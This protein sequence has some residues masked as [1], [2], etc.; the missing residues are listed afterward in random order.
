MALDVFDPAFIRCPFAAY[1]RARETGA[2]VYV[3]E[4]KGFWLV[5]DHAQVR[6]VVGDVETFSSRSGPLAAT[7][8][9]PAARQRMAAI[10][11]PEGVRGRVATLLTLDPPE[12]TRNRRLISR[13]FTP[14]SVRRYEELTRQICRELIAPWRDG[15]EIDFVAEFAVPLPIRII[16]AAL[17]V[18]DDR[19]G[20]F[21]RWSDAAVSG[22]GADLD[23]DDVVA[24]HEALLELG[25]FTQA[26]IERKR[27]A[28][29]AED[30]MSRLVHA[31]LDASDRE[32]LGDEAPSQL[33]D[34]EIHSIIRQ[35]L[36]AGN[37]TT[38]NLLAQS[39]VLL[40]DL[41]DWW[42]RMAAE[43]E[44]IT[45]V[46]EEALRYTSPS[47]ANQRACTRDV[48]LHGAKMAEGDIVLV[49]YLA[50]DHD[51]RVFPDPEV[52]DP[53]RPNLAQH[54]AFGRG[55]HFCPGAALAR[56]EARIAFEELTTAI[57]SY[58][59]PDR[60]TLEWNSSFQLRAMLRLPLR[61]RRQE[62]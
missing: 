1:H 35:L 38:T 60:A 32:E 42:R 37:E 5:T 47:A 41:P 39:I 43:P 10:T 28:G 6:E 13:A 3:S 55:V 57:E 21:K 2:S 30:V 33:T 56:M 19:V 40:H 46:V 25:D 29:P 52:F 14:A 53:D 36:V 7:T 44:V 23:D 26:Q 48:D 4:G 49:G 62:R 59:I 61:P 8:P 20:D 27:A 18:P 17:D 58:E 11:P 31:E 34:D 9:S 12:H 24:A 22:I 51:P 54:L 15:E 50:A 45:A 16:A